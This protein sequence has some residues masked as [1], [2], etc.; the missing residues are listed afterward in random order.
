[1][2]NINFKKYRFFSF[3]TFVPFTVFIQKKFRLTSQDFKILCKK[4]VFGGI[5][6]S[7]RANSSLH[8]TTPSSLIK[9]RLSSCTAR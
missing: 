9:D 6:R 2:N 7:V 8:Q 3:F 5:S 4:D 1:M